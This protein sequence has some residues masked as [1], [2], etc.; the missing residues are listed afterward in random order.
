MHDD[1]RESYSGIDASVNPDE[2]VYMMWS[3]GAR[4]DG[5]D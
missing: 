3:Q 1:S 2:A 5:A 4:A